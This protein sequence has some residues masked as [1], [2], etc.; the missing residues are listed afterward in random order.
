MDRTP[1]WPPAVD[2]DPKRVAKWARGRLASAGVPRPTRVVAAAV[3]PDTWRLVLTFASPPPGTADE[4]RT[5]L[6]PVE[7]EIAELVFRG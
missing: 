1:A 3:T 2:A 6:A 4:A 5:A 7:V